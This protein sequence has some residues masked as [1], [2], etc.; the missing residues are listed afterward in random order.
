MTC[1]SSDI[2][3]K[4]AAKAAKEG[5]ESGVIDLTLDS[6]SDSDIIVSA[7]TPP[8]AGPPKI[9]VRRPKL[10]T[11]NVRQDTSQTRTSTS[12]KLGR[13]VS[14]PRQKATPN[15]ARPWTCGACTLINDA[16]ALRCAVCDGNPPRDP[17]SGWVCL[18]CGTENELQLWMCTTCGVIKN[19]S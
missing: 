3:E 10:A 16:F 8:A 2:A 7:L 18:D 15:D 11:T 1:G 5:I 13:K 4:E 9:G 17:A 19:E 14:T 12:V 6:D